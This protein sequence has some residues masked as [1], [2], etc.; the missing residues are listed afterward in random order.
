[1]SVVSDGNTLI[2]IIDKYIKPLFVVKDKRTDSQKFLDVLED[3]SKG[4]SPLYIAEKLCGVLEDRFVEVHK[5]MK[6]NDEDYYNLLIQI[7]QSIENNFEETISVWKDRLIY[8]RSVKEVWVACEPLLDLID[9]EEG[10]F[11]LLERQLK[12]VDKITYFLTTRTYFDDLI[13]I[14]RSRNFGETKI[15]KL[16]CKII[17]QKLIQPVVIYIAENN[18]Y[19]GMAGKSHPDIAKK[20]D[21]YYFKKTLPTDWLYYLSKDKIQHHYECLS[22]QP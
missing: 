21:E 2:G 12:H 22:K 14:L 8:F 6:G 9:N 10:S 3:V 16:Q 18:N 13:K 15:A 5:K 17:S 20:K 7:V 11:D 4:K 1:M 19:H